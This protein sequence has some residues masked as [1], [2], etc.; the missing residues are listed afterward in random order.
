M[1]KIRLEF[2]SKLEFDLFL[3]FVKIDEIKKACETIKNEDTFNIYSKFL[4]MLENP[5]IIKYS[6]KK[7]AAAATATDVRVKRVKEKIN[8]AINIL[9]LEG[10]KLNFHNI[11]KTA[12]VAY[13][14]VRKYLS[15]EDLNKLNS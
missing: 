5:K 13:L 11:A 2:D 10:K 4:K 15:K 8:N 14:T 3:N 9:K 1:D 12:D 6:D 7:A